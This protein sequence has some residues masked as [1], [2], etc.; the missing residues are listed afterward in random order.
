MTRKHNVRKG[1]SRSRYPERLKKRGVS[2]AQTRMPDFLKGRNRAAD[3]AWT[4]TNITKE[5]SQ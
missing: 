5:K 2:S 1:G 4:D 3:P